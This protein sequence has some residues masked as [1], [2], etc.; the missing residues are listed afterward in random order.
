MKTT[1]NSGATGGWRL[2]AALVAAVG[3]FGVLLLAQA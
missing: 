2:T 1:A 3:L